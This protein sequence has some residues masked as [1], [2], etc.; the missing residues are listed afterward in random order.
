MD[1]IAIH[2]FRVETLIGLHDWER[3]LPQTVQLDLELAIPSG[4][5]GRSDRIEDTI[6]YGAVIARVRE[7]VMAAQFLLLE[8]LCEH[9][10]DLVR[11]EFRSPW[12]RVT[13]T[14]AGVVAGVR[15]VGVTIQRG[16]RAPNEPGER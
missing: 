2:D 12:V 13:C 4:N 8:R 7:S 16:N 14:K 1:T 5:A 9:V 3:R 15:R 6:N 11:E 10:A